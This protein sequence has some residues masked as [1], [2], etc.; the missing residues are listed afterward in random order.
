MYREYARATARMKRN[1][2][3]ESELI[4]KQ[5]DSIFPSHRRVSQPCEGR[6][7]SKAR[8]LEM[9]LWV[10]WSPT[11]WAPALPALSCNILDGCVHSWTVKTWNTKRRKIQDARR[12]RQYRICQSCPCGHGGTWGDTQ[13][14]REVGGPAT[15]EVLSMKGS[16]HPSK[17]TTIQIGIDKFAILFP[18]QPHPS[19]VIGAFDWCPLNVV[20][21]GRAW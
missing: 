3:L 10:R 14:T 16:V 19:V 6:R 7:A 8:S 21:F 18:N 9:S 1:S 15:C 11:A 20:H 17:K 2:R 12:R 13:G 4:D 5:W